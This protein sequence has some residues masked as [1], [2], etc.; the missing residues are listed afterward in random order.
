MPS[1]PAD[2]T[3]G[4]GFLI[5]LLSFPIAGGPGPDRSPPHFC[6]SPALDERFSFYR[7][8]AISFANA[9]PVQQETSVSHHRHYHHKHLKNQLAA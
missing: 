3:H 1:F 4:T 9:K 2:C 8:S 7:S 5:F 6:P